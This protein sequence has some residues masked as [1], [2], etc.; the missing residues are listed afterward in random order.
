MQSSRSYVGI[1]DIRFMIVLNWFVLEGADI[2]NSL[3]TK[4]AISLVEL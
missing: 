3:L 2:Y 1:S 4:E